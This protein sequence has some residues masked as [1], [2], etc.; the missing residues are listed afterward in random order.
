V[1]DAEATLHP[2]E[3]S[4]HSVL[5]YEAVFSGRGP[6]IQGVRIELFHR[7]VDDPRP[8]YENLLEAVSFVPESEPDRVRIAPESS[9]AQGIEVLLRARGDDRLGGWLGYS[10]SRVSDRIDG[11]TVPRS[12]DQPHALTLGLD[13]RPSRRLSLSAAWRLRSGWPTT[14]V[15]QLA[16]PAGDLADTAAAAMPLLVFGELN[17]RRLP[18]YHRLDLR[19]SRLFAVRRGC[20][21]AF[22]DV[23]NF[24][25][26]KNAAGF[27]VAVD[28]E[29]G[30][31][32]RS[33]ESWP[34][35]FPS[36]GV[37]WE[38]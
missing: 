26:H 15:R 17:S 37:A 7:A 28:Q 18:T 5:G 34:G 11:D 10:Y 25:D 8:R 6:G 16:A 36:I 29:T 22:L 24:Y 32:A 20:L 23:Q 12:L 21:T 4:E 14:P 31:L 19:L 35:I 30:A 33:R 38:L 1:G 2:A 13:Y 27:D 9:S 3:L